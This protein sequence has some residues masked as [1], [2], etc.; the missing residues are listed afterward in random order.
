[1]KENV[2]TLLLTLLMSMVGLRAFADW[3]TSKKVQVDGLYFQLD[4]DNLQAQVTEK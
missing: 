3:D 2:Y 4:R 1:M